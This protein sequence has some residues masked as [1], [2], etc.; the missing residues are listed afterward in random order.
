MSAL[1][2][3]IDTV[4]GM[5]STL[6]PF[7][8]L[9]GYREVLKRVLTR[10]DFPRPDSPGKV[11]MKFLASHQVQLLTNNHDIKIEALANTLAMPLIGQVGKSNVA[12]E[13]PPHN[14][15]HITS[16]LSCSLGIFG[17]DSLGGNLCI[18][19]HWVLALA[20]R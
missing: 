9:G 8:S 12:C 18:G 4:F 7:R 15:P 13:L 16:S 6:G 5:M 14:V 11:S 1:I 20:V 19:G 17:A 10:V 2:D 3:W